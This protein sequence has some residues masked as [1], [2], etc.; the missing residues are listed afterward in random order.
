MVHPTEVGYVRCPSL[1]LP[2]AGKTWPKFGSGPAF[3]SPRRV[4]SDA[5]AA[6]SLGAAA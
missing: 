3:A 4:K 6:V 5:G 1:V 2:L